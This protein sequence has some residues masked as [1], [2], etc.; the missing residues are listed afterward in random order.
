MQNL[1]LVLFNVVIL[2]SHTSGIVC[3]KED[4]IKYFEKQAPTLKQ[5]C[6]DVIVQSIQ[7]DSVDT[8]T[9]LK[10]IEKFSYFPEELDRKITKKM[11]Y[12]GTGH[13]YHCGNDKKTFDYKV[14]FDETNKYV[15]VVDDKD[16]TLTQFTMNGEKIRGFSLPR[17]H[18][19]Y[20]GSVVVHQDYEEI[21]SLHIIKEDT[22]RTIFDAPLASHCNFKKILRNQQELVWGTS[23]SPFKTTLYDFNKDLKIYESVDGIEFDKDEKICMVTNDNTVII[24]TPKKNKDRSEYKQKIVFND[25]EKVCLNS[26]GKQLLIERKDQPVELIDIEEQKSIFSFKGVKEK[27]NINTAKF[28]D[29]GNY[30]IVGS[31]AKDKT[32]H[33]LDTALGKIFMSVCLSEHPYPLFDKKYLVLDNKDQ[34]CLVPVK[35]LSKMSEFSKETTSIYT[36]KEIVASGMGKAYNA[37]FR[38]FHPN[39]KYIVLRS[40]NEWKLVDPKTGKSLFVA[41]NIVDHSF[42]KPTGKMICLKNIDYKGFE[43]FSLRNDFTITECLLYR[44]MKE[45]NISASDLSLYPHMQEIY[46]KMDKDKQLLLHC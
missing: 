21:P 14:M 25:I 7:K 10:M 36:I 6:S 17:G 30:L 37:D 3:M 38:G 35:N 16:A 4:P 19:C 42:S 39:G 22:K 1:R 20:N 18:S 31:Y 44:F 24:S 2:L 45:K 5:L 32:F 15:I 12:Y 43:C 29:D 27:I 9:S 28:S 33:I 40:K 46:N 13:K 26:N 8:L 41:N 23:S 34:T 11:L